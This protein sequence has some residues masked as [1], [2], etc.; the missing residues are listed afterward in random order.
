MLFVKIHAGKTKLRKHQRASVAKQFGE[1]VGRGEGGKACEIMEGVEGEDAVPGVP[2]SEG[3]NAADRLLG[4]VSL[5][6]R[7]SGS[8]FHVWRVEMLGIIAVRSLS[9]AVCLRSLDVEALCTVCSGVG[10][11]TVL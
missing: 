8:G 3:Y 9:I 7:V 6:G 10:L 2:G 11:Q 4:P 5:C 1:L